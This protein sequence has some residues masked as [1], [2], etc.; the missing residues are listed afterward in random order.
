MLVVKHQYVGSK[1]PISFTTKSN[2]VIG[3]TIYKIYYRTTTI[4][5]SSHQIRLN[6]SNSYTDNLVVT[7]TINTSNGLNV[8]SKAPISFTTNRN[9][10]LNGTTFSCYDIDLTKYTKYIT[11]KVKGMTLRSRK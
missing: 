4:A 5:L 9:V 6:A 11:N 1:A 10:V 3:A 7:G 8:G 2:V